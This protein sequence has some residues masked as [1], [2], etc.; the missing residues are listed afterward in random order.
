M[1]TTI[2]LDPALLAQAKKLAAET[3]RTLTA[4]IE[5]ALREVV[6]RRRRPVR[7]RVKLT[8]VGGRGLSPG[9]DLDDTASLLDA[10]DARGSD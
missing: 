3:H 9:I 5:D 10:M 2:R 8:V 4:V 7:R 6:S 1:R